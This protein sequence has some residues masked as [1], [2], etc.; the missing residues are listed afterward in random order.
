MIYNFKILTGLL[1]IA[2]IG[3]SK[4]ELPP[5]ERFVRS[6]LPADFK[7]IFYSTDQNA[8]CGE[9]G[10]EKTG[11]F[12]RFFSHWKDRRIAY[13]GTDDYTFKEFVAACNVK[14]TAQEI[15]TEEARQSAEKA[16]EHEAVEL[17][18][19]R[20]AKELWMEQNGDAIKAMHDAARQ[21]NGR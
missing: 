18:K 17:E 13:E 2:L 14:M 7:D 1:V 9:V 15:A 19:M 12:R 20:M 8:I 16:A 21:L 3:C 11:K 10:N 6:R 4:P 5:A